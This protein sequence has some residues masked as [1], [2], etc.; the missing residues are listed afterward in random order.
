MKPERI[1]QVI[2]EHCGWKFRNCDDGSGGWLH[3]LDGKPNFNNLI[4]NYCADLNA[5][6]DAENFVTK[7]LRYH[8]IDILGESFKDSWEFCTATAS[9][10]AEAFLKT[11]G[12]W[13][14][15]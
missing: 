1:N 13:E 6:H 9:Q 5:M 15:E 11:I 4:P 7:E 3:K 8:Y 10:R 12:K 14:E 2:A